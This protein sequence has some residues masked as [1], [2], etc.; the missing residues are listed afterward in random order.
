MLICSASGPGRPP[1]IADDRLDRLRLQN[2]Q[3]MGRRV[4]ADLGGPAGVAPGRGRYSGL[5]PLGHLLPRDAFG[6][7]RTDR[8]ELQFK[9]FFG[10]FLAW[11]LGSCWRRWPDTSARAAGAGPSTPSQGFV[12]QRSTSLPRASEVS[13]AASAA[14]SIAISPPTASAR[15]ARIC[16]QRRGLVKIGRHR[17]IEQ[18]AGLVQ[19]RGQRESFG[20]FAAAQRLLPGVAKLFAKHEHLLMDIAGLQTTIALV[21]LDRS[22]SAA[23]LP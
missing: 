4:E 18:L 10:G 14:W 1:A 7:P 20:V 21:D 17:P 11:S 2:D 9:P 13:A 16:D 12:S 5:Q 6:Q 3:A 23:G 22:P 19:A 8:V 15:N